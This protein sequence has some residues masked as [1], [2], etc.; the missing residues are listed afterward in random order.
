MATHLHELDVDVITRSHLEKGLARLRDELRA[1][2]Q[3]E[4]SIAKG[5]P[6]VLFVCVENAGQSQMAAGP[7]DKRAGDEVLDRMREIRDEI[8]DRA[9]ALLGELSRDREDAA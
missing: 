4:G 1:L 6:E 8:G 7:L 5:V 2:G 3:V 9:R